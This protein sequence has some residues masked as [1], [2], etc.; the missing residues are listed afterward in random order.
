MPRNARVLTPFI[1]FSHYMGYSLENHRT[2][3]IGSQQPSR[4]V[5]VYCFYQYLRDFA[6]HLYLER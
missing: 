2:M 4:V 5:S 3:E 1:H 6:Y